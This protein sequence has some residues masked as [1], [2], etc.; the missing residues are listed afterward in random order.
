[1]SGPT[2]EEIDLATVEALR[3]QMAKEIREPL[4]KLVGRPL[5]YAEAKEAAMAALH[6][7]LERGCL[8]VPRRRK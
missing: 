3:D 4:S 6:K 8:D 5:D 7:V 2:R 1:M